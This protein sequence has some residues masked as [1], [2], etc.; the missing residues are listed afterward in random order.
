MATGIANTK[1]G[2]V[3]YTDLGPSDG[4]VV[5]FSTGGGTSFN[6]V[7]AFKWISLEGFRIISINRPG[8]HDLVLNAASSIEEHADIYHSVIEYLEIEGPINVFGI[9][10]GG[11][12]ALYYAAKYPTK[13][14]VLWSAITGKYRV[15]KASTNSLLGKLVLNR[16]GKKLISWMLKVS[17]RQFPRMTMD[18]FLKTEADLNEK[19]RRKIVEEMMLDDQSKEEFTLFIESMLPMDSMY[20][21][22]IDEVKK[23]EQLGPVDWSTI[24]CPTY[25]FHSTVDKDVAIEHPRRLEETLSNIKMNYVKAGGHFI[26]W[27]EEGKAVKQNTLCFLHEM[28]G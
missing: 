28:N 11:L 8:Y 20:E 12:S 10:M 21:G 4:N 18:V 1:Y 2:D 24:K 3:K 25:V 23:A 19:E 27:G 22:M 6:L 14:L 9:S 17:A 15:N 5:L 16:Y 26:W 13:S 7:Q